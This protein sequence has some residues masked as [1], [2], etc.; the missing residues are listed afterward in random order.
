MQREEIYFLKGLKGA[1]LV[2][3]FSPDGHFLAAADTEGHVLVWDMET[4]LLA[5]SVRHCPAC[6]TRK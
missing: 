3:E 2:A 5:T 1:V 4:G 6:S